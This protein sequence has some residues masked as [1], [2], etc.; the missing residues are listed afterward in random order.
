MRGLSILRSSE[1]SLA[2]QIKSSVYTQSSPV[3]WFHTD[4]N[5]NWLITSPVSPV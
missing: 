4:L 1:G 5:H 3:T 2:I